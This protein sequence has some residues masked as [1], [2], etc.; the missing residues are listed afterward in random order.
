MRGGVVV[1]KAA[2]VRKI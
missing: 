2:G 1:R